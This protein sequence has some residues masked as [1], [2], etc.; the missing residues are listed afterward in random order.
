MSE[1]FAAE[2]L[3]SSFAIALRVSF[4]HFHRSQYRQEFILSDSLANSCWSVEQ[5]DVEPRLRKYFHGATI[6]IRQ[7]HCIGGQSLRRITLKNLNE[8]I[9]RADVEESP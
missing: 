2:M 9:V 8:C 5:E 7:N 3:C 4:N 1:A 6:P